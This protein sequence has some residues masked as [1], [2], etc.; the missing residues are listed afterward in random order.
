[1]DNRNSKPRIYL[2]TSVPSHLY[3]TDAPAQTIDTW[4]LWTTIKTGDY[5]AFISPTVI[6]ELEATLQPKRSLII[7][8]INLAGIE[9]LK[10]SNDV[11]RLANNYIKAGILGNKHY[12]D[13]MHMA[14]ASIY[15]CDA[16]ISWNFRHLVKIKTID[17][18][19]AVNANNQYGKIVIVSPAIL[20]ERTI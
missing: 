17:G 20:L 14:F 3:D 8:E 11:T 4:R 6:D 13:C 10:I 15:K 16:L 9:T 18:A 1:M 7:N 12:N 2:D 5:D 19:Q